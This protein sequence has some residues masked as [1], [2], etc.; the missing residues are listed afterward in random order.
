MA[1]K[2]TKPKTAGAAKA[3]RRKRADE[4]EIAAIGARW[5]DEDEQL[6]LIE[7]MAKESIGLPIEGLVVGEAVQVTE[8]YYDGTV[9][10]GLMTRCRRGDANY[11]VSFAALTFPEGSSAGRW[12]A[13]YASWL[14]VRMQTGKSESVDVAKPVASVTPPGDPVAS[15][16]S[17]PTS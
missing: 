1:K 11:A 14:S 15:R 16:M 2:A 10:G 3:A 4:L 8:I 12:A 9:R 13:N 5:E 7:R 6:R 17:R